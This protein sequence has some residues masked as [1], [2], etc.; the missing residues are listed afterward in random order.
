M[1]K[2]N[3]TLELEEL[4]NKYIKESVNKALS[5]QEVKNL[6]AETIKNKVAD[7][8]NNQT[9]GIFIP[10]NVNEVMR[11]KK[12][13]PQTL[14]DNQLVNVT[15]N[16]EANPIYAVSDEII[17]DFSKLGHGTSVTFY[18]TNNYG[19]QEQFT[20]KINIVDQGHTIEVMEC[21]NNL[22]I[23]LE[24]Y[25][26]NHMQ[27]RDFKRYGF[28]TINF[29]SFELTKGYLAL[30]RLRI[31]D[32]VEVGGK[33]YLDL[34]EL[35]K[36][37]LNAK[38]EFKLGGVKCKGLANRTFNIE[39]NPLLKE[40]H[41]EDKISLFKLGGIVHKASIEKGM[42]IQADYNSD[43]SYYYIDIEGDIYEEI[44]ND[45]KFKELVEKAE[46]LFDYEEEHQKRLII[47]DQDIQ[48]LDIKKIN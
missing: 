47:R 4:V 26:S 38:V 14:N 24:A 7:I 16:S 45:S 31:T 23:N 46:D 48:E 42:S 11:D 22:K 28:S 15:N 43:Y 3:Y 1:E 12:I 37:E 35:A 29:S 13:N 2:S 20:G 36:L 25:L 40:L 30:I 19:V 34:S 10:F 18:L 5:T 39:N 17:N 8:L 44:K 33:E 32:P 41:K 21:I 27:Y 9:K 6:I